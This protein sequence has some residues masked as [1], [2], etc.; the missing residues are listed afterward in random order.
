[1]YAN[2]W[3][4]VA[5]YNNA[6]GPPKSALLINL[7]IKNLDIVFKAYFTFEMVRVRLWLTS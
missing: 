3:T 6:E 1:M 5:L 4:L 7:I 2:I